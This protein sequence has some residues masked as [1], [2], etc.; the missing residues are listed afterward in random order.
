MY[1]LLTLCNIL[2]FYH[3]VFIYKGFF[4]INQELSENLSQFILT[5]IQYCFL[6]IS[7]TN[8]GITTLSH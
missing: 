2:T 6:L 3:R 7:I 5:L 4:L 8:K 1:I